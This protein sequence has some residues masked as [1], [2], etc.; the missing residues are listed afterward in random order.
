ML[1]QRAFGIRSSCSPICSSSTR[2]DSVESLPTSEIGL[3]EDWTLQRGSVLRRRVPDHAVRP[4]GEQQ[5]LLLVA[6]AV[7]TKTGLHVDHKAQAHLL[8][9]RAPPAETRGPARAITRGL[10]SSRATP[11]T[12]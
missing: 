9:C 8:N 2:R 1:S 3:M 10:A 12:R 4:I 6:A 7:N 5:V 11:P